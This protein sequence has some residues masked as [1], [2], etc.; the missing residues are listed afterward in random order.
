MRPGLSV[1]IAVLAAA[2]VAGAGQDEK[3]TRDT[4]VMVVTGCINR[5]M[6]E[7]RQT[8]TYGSHTDRFRLRGSKDLMKTLTKD[9]DGHLVEVTGVVKDPDN[10]QGRGKTIQVGKKTTITTGARDVPS[11]LDIKRDPI[12]DVE[13]FKS[14]K[15]DCKGS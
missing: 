2:V 15:D 8:D 7:V 12:L 1:F 5:T 10:T 9:N 13:S 4:R 14:L 11:P 3:K 6:L